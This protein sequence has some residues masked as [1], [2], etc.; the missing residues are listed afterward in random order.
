[1]NVMLSEKTKTVK[2]DIFFNFIP[3]V[4]Y[5]AKLNELDKEALK[6]LV[7]L[8]LLPNIG[9]VRARNI[10]AHFGDVKSVFENEKE[11]I[12]LTPGKNKLTVT[13]IIEAQNRAEEELEWTEKN[14]VKVISYLDD[15]YPYRLKNLHDHPLV[16]CYKGE[17][18]LNYRK[19]IGIVGTRRA[20]KY[21]ES[22][23][24]EIME[25]VAPYKPLI[26]S[27]LAYGV[28]KMA[29]QAALNNNLETVGVLGHGL[30]TIYPS[31]HK[32]LANKMEVQGGLLSEF[33]SGSKFDKENFPKR[34]RIVAGMLDALIVVETKRKG[35][36]M[37]TADIAFAA[38]REVFAVPGNIGQQNSE[39]C[40]Y[41]IR[42]LKAQILDNP[43]EFP[44]Q[45]NWGNIDELPDNTQFEL[46]L[47][48]NEQEK[49]IIK[50]LQKNKEMSIDQLCIQLQ[51]NSG[52]L[53]E[54][55]LQLE[56]KGLI[57]QRP[58]KIYTLS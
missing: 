29:H 44:K 16:L 42:L 2:R 5:S 33:L 40:N 57:I 10:L 1:M 52:F 26:I 45:M 8:G 34:N 14:N 18:N 12:Q 9:P 56:F 17:A 54:K 27:G 51:R 30:H 37:I 20:S 35:G 4:F 15:A 53:A 36:S 24:N 58:G 46:P 11:L 22:V 23:V 48:L 43:V 25:V 13:E 50:L 55:L 19:V 41:L 47:D 32:G 39:G 49:N 6:Y 31:V 28:D 7:A 21:G 3:I 38:N